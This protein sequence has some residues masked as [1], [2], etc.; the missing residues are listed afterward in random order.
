MEKGGGGAVLTLRLPHHVAHG[1]GLGRV[2]GNG[3]SSR[4]HARVHPTVLG[5]DVL[6]QQTLVMLLL[7]HVQV[8][9]ARLA[10]E[11]HHSSLAAGTLAMHTVRWRLDTSVCATDG[12]LAIHN[13]LK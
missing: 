12:F 13:F 8:L 2:G 4:V 6:S 1:A 11:H 9:T 5:Q 10:L 3:T 7:D